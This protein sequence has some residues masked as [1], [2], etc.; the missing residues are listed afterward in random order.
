MKKQLLSLAILFFSIWTISA[1]SYRYGLVRDYNNTG[2]NYEFT[3]VIIPD[4]DNGNVLVGAAQITISITAG[5]TFS[6]F[7]QINGNNW[8]STVFNAANLN[9][10]S[11]GDGTRD[12]WAFNRTSDSPLNIASHTT[13]QQI[14]LFSFVVDN[15]PTTGDITLTENT[16]ATIVDLATN[17]SGGFNFSNTFPADID[18]TPIMDS[19]FY[20]NNFAGLVF[21]ELADPLLNVEEVAFS[22]D[23]T[24]VPNPA[25]TSF[26]IKGANG[27][28][29]DIKIFDINGGLVKSIS[30]NIVAES[31]S[32]KEMAAGVYFVQLTSQNAVKTI[33]LVKE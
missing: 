29:D 1:Q 11:A 33:K 10:F 4:F 21:Y 17:S 15:M 2:A 12:L 19:E 25:I 30:E 18:G 13:G 14:P 5:N 27:I 3:F 9:S 7:T 23:I 32:V 26:A 8:Q 24:V 22:S 28:I 16:D 31:V 6:N 20:G